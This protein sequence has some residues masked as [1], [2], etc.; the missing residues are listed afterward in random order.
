LATREENL[1]FRYGIG[2]ED[3][4]EMYKNQKGK[5][6]ICRKKKKKLDVDHCHRT[7]KIRGLL[8]NSCNQGLG[9]FKD[10]EKIMKQA[11]N[12]LKS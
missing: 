2:V 11:A 10:D 5:C 12:Y 8:C 9:L 7:G 1:R 4:E 6:A 3:Y